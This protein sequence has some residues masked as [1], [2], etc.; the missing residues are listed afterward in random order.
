MGVTYFSDQPGVQFYTGNMMADKYEGKENRK[1]GLQYGLCVEPQFFPDA[2]N[3]ENFLSPII[4]ANEIYTST[5][6]MK[7]YNNF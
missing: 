2:I 7:L 3:Q 6:V 4:K 1:Y 5:I